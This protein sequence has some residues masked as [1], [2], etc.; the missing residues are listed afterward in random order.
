MPAGPVGQ[1][2]AAPLEAD[3]ILTRQMGAGW[4]FF[5]W[6]PSTTGGPSRGVL[7]SGEVRSLWRAEWLVPVLRRAACAAAIGAIK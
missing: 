4:E 1:P 7:C 5:N 6:G 2:R 3:D